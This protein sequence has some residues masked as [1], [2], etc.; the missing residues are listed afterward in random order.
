[1]TIVPNIVT[2]HKK[3][4]DTKELEQFKHLSAKLEVTSNVVIT[5]KNENKQISP[6]TAF[7]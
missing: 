2:E 1:M 4:R 6:D 5:K 3:G 7:R